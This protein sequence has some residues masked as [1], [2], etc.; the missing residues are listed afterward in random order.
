MAAVAA[1]PGALAPGTSTSPSSTSQRRPW[2]ACATGKCACSEEQ[3]A[4]S[5]Q[6][7]IVQ[8]VHQLNPPEN[9]KKYLTRPTFV[10]MDCWHA[11]AAGCCG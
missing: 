7:T 11:C 2:M 3:S 1:T 6:E 5:Q 4:V 10:D 8:T 9:C